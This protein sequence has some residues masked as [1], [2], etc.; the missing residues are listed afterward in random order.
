MPRFE[1]CWYNGRSILDDSKANGS[2]KKYFPEHLHVIPTTPDHT[3]SKIMFVR[4]ELF[5]P[6]LKTIIHSPHPHYRITFKVSKQAH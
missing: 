3:F 6:H 2:R 4:Q 5:Q 1:M